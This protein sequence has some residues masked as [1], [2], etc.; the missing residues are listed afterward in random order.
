MNTEDLAVKIQEVADRSLRNEGRIK[1]LESEQ[2]SIRSLATSV[3]VMAEQLK[4][5]NTSVCTLTNKVEELEEKPG[6]RW[7]SIVEKIIW[8]I[9]A[10]VIAFLLG[11]IGL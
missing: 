8:A 3:A 2:E 9:A 7:E 5:M 6:K 10:A 1:K 4:T 11:R